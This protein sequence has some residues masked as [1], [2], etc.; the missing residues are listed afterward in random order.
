MMDS[1][2][3]RFRLQQIGYDDSFCCLGVDAKAKPGYIIIFLY[4][5]GIKII[6]LGNAT[7]QQLCK[8]HIFIGPYLFCDP[9]GYTMC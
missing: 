3:G 5:E 6:R 7:I 8:V 1:V 2:D 4:L 9:I